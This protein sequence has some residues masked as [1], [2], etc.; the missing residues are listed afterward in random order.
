MANETLG[1]GDIIN[2]GHYDVRLVEA[3]Y[4]C[5]DGWRARG[6]RWVPSRKA[7]QD[8]VAVYGWRGEPSAPKFFRRSPITSA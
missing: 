1:P 6:V 8:K 5:E 4:Q 3:P 2:N 7:W